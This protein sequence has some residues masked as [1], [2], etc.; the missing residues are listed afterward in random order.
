VWTANSLYIPKH[1][2]ALRSPEKKVCVIH[3]WML[4]K[5]KNE[6]GNLLTLAAEAKMDKLFNRQSKE[7]RVR[8]THEC[9]QPKPP[10]H[11]VM[12]PGTTET[13]RRQKNV[14]LWK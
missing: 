2:R 1:V 8:N 14:H 10:H 4:S 12:T 3:L 6:N 13:T 7:S 5:S 9:M 11:P